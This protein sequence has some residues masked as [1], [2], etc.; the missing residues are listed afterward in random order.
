MRYAKT[1][2][3]TN[4][5]RKK[6][7]GLEEIGGQLVLDLLFCKVIL[8]CVFCLEFFIIGNIKETLNFTH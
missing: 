7:E 5:R 6:K 4:R 3:E 1:R 8:C 2:E